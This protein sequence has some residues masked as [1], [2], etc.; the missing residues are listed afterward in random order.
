MQK[1]RKRSSTRQK[2]S[3]QQH[4]SHRSYFVNKPLSNY[5]LKDWVKQLGIKHFRGV[6]SRDTLAEQMKNKECGIVNLDSHIGPGT[7]WV[8]YRNID[9][10]CEYFDSFGLAMPVEVKKYMSTSGKQLVYS[11]DEIQERDSV[12]CGYWCL[13]YLLE[14]QRGRSILETIH[15]SK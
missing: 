12:L 1:G 6:F 15:N 3:I 14:R 4:P 5:Y 11:G 9:K 8:A 10:Y 2:Q 7:H 13:Y